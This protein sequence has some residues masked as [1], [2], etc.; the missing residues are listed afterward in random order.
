MSGDGECF[1]L[2]D[3]LAGLSINLKQFQQM[4]IAAG[5]DYHR[6]VKGV[7]RYSIPFC[8][9]VN[10]KFLGTTLKEGI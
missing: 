5:C 3:I 10:W 7:G 9:S 4:C 8:S 6:N 2:A 1:L